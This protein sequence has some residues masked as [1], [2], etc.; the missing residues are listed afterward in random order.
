MKVLFITKHDVARY[1]LAEVLSALTA[2]L[3]HHGVEAVTYSSHESARAGML[4]DGRR[5]LHGPLPKPGRWS[6]RTDAR[7]LAATARDIGAEV[8]H[9]HGLHHAGFAGMMVKRLTG[10]PLVV[11]SH[12]DITRDKRRRNPLFRWR[13]GR[14]LK[15]ADAVTHLGDAMMG[16]AMEMANVRAKSTIIP[17]GVDTRWWRGTGA[18]VA[19]RY[20]L[21]VGRLDP[22]KG[23]DVLIRAMKLLADRGVDIGLVIAGEGDAGGALRAEATGIG[24]R[25]A[26]GLGAVPTAGRGAVCFAGFVQGDDKRNLA[27]GAT[28]ISFSS[29]HGEVAPPLAVLEAMAAGKAIV[30]SDIPAARSILVPGQNAELVAAG[31]PAA[32]ADAIARVAGNDGLRTAYEQQN[33]RLIEQYDWTSI[34][35]R[36]AEVYRALSRKRGG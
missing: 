29:Q 14:V 26:E 25:V 35:A 20:V 32:W 10:L 13:C 17:N 21:A 33:R 27:A 7:K 2:S 18:P 28:L 23:F 9:C 16:Y 24:L 4:P 30:G 36:Y 34:A 1:G 11:T 15:A 6:A 22:Q 31:D 5:C 19:G 12:G 8:L 3:A